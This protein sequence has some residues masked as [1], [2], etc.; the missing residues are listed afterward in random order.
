MFGFVESSLHCVTFMLESPL[1]MY[2]LPSH[3]ND[4][5]TQFVTHKSKVSFAPY[6][7]IN[8]YVEV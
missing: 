2:L 1:S 5:G 7:T 3:P 6:L 8:Q 4:E